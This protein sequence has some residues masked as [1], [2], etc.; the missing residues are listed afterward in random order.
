MVTIPLVPRFDLGLGGRWTSLTG[1]G[2]EWLW[3]RHDP[4]RST[5][6]PGAPF[7]DAGGLE[8]CVPTVRGLP[9]HGDV[10][11]RPW[12]GSAAFSSV[13][14]ADFELSRTVKD[15][16]G[17]VV[18]TYRLSADPGYRFVWAAHALL[19]LSERAR[20]VA[21]EGTVA[22]LYPEA[23]PL[24]PG[25][26]PSAAA[27]LDGSWP[28]PHGLELDRLGAEDGT[29]V[30]AVLCCV[31]VRVVDGA[32]A[33]DLRVEAPSGVPVATALWRNL[34]GF[35]EGSP[36]RSIGVEPMLGTVFDLAEAG[37]DDA[38]VVPPS[39][40]LTWRLVLA[41]ERMS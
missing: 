14:C 9:D 8:E 35:P 25:V 11:S 41:A 23:A 32:D 27:Y 31:A 26:W 7:V 22:R 39:G 4:A 28:A 13:R 34:G 18:A 19:D 40:E 5:V 12:T 2:R 6:S 38:A 15:E 16:A 20:L 30:G 37:P 1:G 36:Y 10:W 17:A 33:L 21:P 24:L 3:S 29:A